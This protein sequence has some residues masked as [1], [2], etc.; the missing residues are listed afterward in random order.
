MVPS[1]PSH[2]L[3][4]LVPNLTTK[5]RE[6]VK[7]CGA[8]RSGATRSGATRSGA[9]RS[10]ATRSGATRSGA[11]RSGATRSGA[12]R[13]GATRS[14]ATRSGATRSGATRSGA[15]RSGATR[16]G[17]TRSGATRSGATRSGATRS[18]ESA[19]LS[20]DHVGQLELPDRRPIKERLQSIFEPPMSSDEESVTREKTEENRKKGTV[21]KREPSLRKEKGK[22]RASLL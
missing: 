9:T 20:V 13:S 10:G 4:I 5:P 16:S 18:P 22:I 8:T 7:I 1:V 15:T 3:H 19:L 11:T 17:A 12:T 14:G 21:E 2:A 6:Y